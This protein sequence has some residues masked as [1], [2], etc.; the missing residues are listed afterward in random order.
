VSWL[1]RSSDAD[2]IA[3]PQVL[4]QVLGHDVAHD[5]TPKALLAPRGRFLLRVTGTCT[6]YDTRYPVT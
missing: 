3:S 4:D 2:E 1:W 5:P 6:E